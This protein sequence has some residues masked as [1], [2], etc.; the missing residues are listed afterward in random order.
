MKKY[1]KTDFVPDT[2][3][4]LITGK[5]YE[6]LN[7]Y[8]T[9]G[10]I[11]NETGAKTHINYD[12][13]GHIGLGAWEFCDA[14]GK[15]VDK[16]Y[17]SLLEAAEAVVRQLD[18]AAQPLNEPTLSMVE[19]LRAVLARKRPDLVPTLEPKRR[20]QGWYSVGGNME[21]IAGPFIQKP[22]QSKNPIY[23]VPNLW[24]AYIDSTEGDEPA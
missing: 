11:I 12:C 1:V 6:I 23:N 21:I 24:Y 13:C 8:Q 16:D 20:V 3:P 17:L 7:D 14:N 10:E 9:Y 5:V 18:V 19:E 15:L 22:S 4:Y 2:V